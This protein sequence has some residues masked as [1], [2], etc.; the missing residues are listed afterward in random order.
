MDVEESFATGKPGSQ[1]STNLQQN[2]ETLDM[3]RELDACRKKLKD[4]EHKVQGLSYLTDALACLRKELE[5]AH[6]QLAQQRSS[7]I[8]IGAGLVA[9]I[10][11]KETVIAANERAIEDMRS[12]IAAQEKKQ[13]AH[14]AVLMNMISEKDEALD[15]CESDL[16]IMQSK[17]H[18]L[19]MPENASF[20]N[21][22]ESL[23]EIKSCKLLCSDGHCQFGR[24]RL[25]QNFFG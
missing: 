16:N 20:M 18:E 2:D 15:G 5:E 10:A 25:R 7:Q 24:R 3:K 4:A 1:E 6:E 17:L 23:A 13:Q 21:C 19:E 22:S 8:P 14:V 11:E 12:T 9:Q